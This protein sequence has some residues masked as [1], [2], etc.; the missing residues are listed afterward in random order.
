MVSYKTLELKEGKKSSLNLNLYDDYTFFASQKTPVT[1]SMTAVDVPSQCSLS[2]AP[3]KQGEP[4]SIEP[5]QVVQ[6]TVTVSCTAAVPADAH[7][8]VVLTIIGGDAKEML[9]QDFVDL[10]PGTQ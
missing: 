6:L 1:Y 4:I 3:Y 9:S 2:T 7:G 8:Q 10:F 5:Q